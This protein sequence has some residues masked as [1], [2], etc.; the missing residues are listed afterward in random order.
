MSFLE[1]HTYSDMLGRLPSV[2]GHVKI[3]HSSMSCPYGS[4]A[5]C[6]LSYSQVDIRSGRSHYDR[7][8]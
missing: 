3:D 7:R 5:S 4:Q 1:R 2:H 8:C 6:V